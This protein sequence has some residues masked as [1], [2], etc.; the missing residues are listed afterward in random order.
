MFYKRIVFINAVP[1]F[2]PLSVVQLKDS[3][4]NP[5]PKL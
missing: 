5:E 2:L 4:Q 1:F 3:A